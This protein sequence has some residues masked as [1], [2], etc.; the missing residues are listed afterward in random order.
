[1]IISNETADHEELIKNRTNWPNLYTIIFIIR[2][3]KH[4][5]KLTEVNDFNKFYTDFDKELVSERILSQLASYNMYDWY[6]YLYT[7]ASR[8]THWLDFVLFPVHFRDF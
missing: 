1:M 3:Y 2:T 5:K 6:V 4:A 7:L 8:N